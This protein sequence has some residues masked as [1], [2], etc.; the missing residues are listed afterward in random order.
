MAR[1]WTLPPR[2]GDTRWVAVGCAE[3]FQLVWAARERDT[4]PGTSLSAV[5]LYQGVAPGVGVLRMHLR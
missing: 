5:L 2:P 3:E 4:D 1:A